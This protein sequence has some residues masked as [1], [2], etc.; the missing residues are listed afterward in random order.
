[1]LLHYTN[2]TGWRMT[3]GREIKVCL[4]DRKMSVWC[5][6]CLPHRGGARGL[7]S[8]TLGSQLYVLVSESL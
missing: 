5:L 6:H 2:Q 7:N 4:S 8:S 3:L 1:M